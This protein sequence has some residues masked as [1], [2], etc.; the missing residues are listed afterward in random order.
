MNM[1]PRRVLCL[2]GQQPIKT[3]IRKPAH[4]SHHPDP[5]SARLYSL[6]F[7]SFQK[8]LRIPLFQAN[9]G[10]SAIGHILQNWLTDVSIISWAAWG[11][12]I[13]GGQFFRGARQT[14]KVLTACF[15]GTPFSNKGP[16][17]TTVGHIFF[18]LVNW[19]A[20]SWNKNKIWPSADWPYHGVWT[21]NTIMYSQLW[22][23]PSL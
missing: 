14:S 2:F 11:R 9:M 6:V 8:D 16:I 4:S 23:T 15:W 18:C 22:D 12:T 20:N 21:C 1:S 17:C 10:Q 13:S 5:S 19:P 3:N 7:E